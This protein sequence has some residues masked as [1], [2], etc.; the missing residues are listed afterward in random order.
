M[1]NGEKK[2]HKRL[3]TLREHVTTLDPDHKKL[4]GGKAAIACMFA[5]YGSHDYLEGVSS[6]SI[7]LIHPENVPDDLVT[8]FLQPELIGLRTP[9]IAELLKIHGDP[10]LIHAALKLDEDPVK[11]GFLLPETRDDL[12][13]EA[14]HRTSSVIIHL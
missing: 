5:E 13:R 10:V 9:I 12:Q 8:T 6:S 2:Y 11:G 3:L 1:S 7:A 4:L 14:S